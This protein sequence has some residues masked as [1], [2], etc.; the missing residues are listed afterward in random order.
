[1]AAP[2]RAG[3]FL[4][5]TPALPVTLPTFQVNAAADWFA[6]SFTPDSGRTLS[7]VRAF[8][9]AVAGT[10]GASDITCDLYDSTGSLGAPGASV[11]AG[12]VPSATIT[13]S[14][15]YDFTG[16]TTALTAGLKYYAVFKNVNGTPASNNP[17][18]RGIGLGTPTLT[19]GGNS[20]RFGWT[21]ATS[22]NSGGSWSQV[23]TQTGVRI[24]YADG[25]YDGL[26]V[27]NTA[28]AAV[29]DGVYSTRESGVKFTTP[30]NGVLKVAG[31]AICMAS[32]T[33]VP[34]GNVQLGLWSGSTPS[35]VA[36]TNP[37]PLAVATTAQ[38]VYA[39]FSST[40]TVQPGTVLRVT[41]AETAQSDTSA[42]YYKNQEITWD[43]DVNSTALL[44]WEG[45]CVKTYFDG[46]S[47]TDTSGSIFAHALLLDPA[48]EFGAG[49]GGSAGS[50]V[51]PS[52]VL[53]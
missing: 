49:A 50:V 8:V 40:Q 32:R 30:P 1:M 41:L 53:I 28:A 14:G 5:W 4:G 27:S 52:N 36:Y 15:W 38:W 3:Q 19:L 22:T 31:L 16:F 25:T 44:P 26:P 12:K 42:T 11:E 21:W 51:G 7:A 34:T 39:Y 9:S 2:F 18:F 35:L 6:L 48:G 24:A 47:W 46:S 43:T 17:T 13:A 33:G 10:L 45:A 37:V 23:G 29:T 20:S